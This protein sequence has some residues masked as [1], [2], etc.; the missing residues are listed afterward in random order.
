LF[1]GNT[2]TYKEIDHESPF[3][4]SLYSKLHN[5]PAILKLSQFSI[6]DEC[7]NAGYRPFD[8]EEIHGHWTE[9]AHKFFAERIVEIYNSVYN[10]KK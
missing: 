6:A 4:K 9:P 1:S 2:Y 8:T 10:L 7:W 5:D 3:I